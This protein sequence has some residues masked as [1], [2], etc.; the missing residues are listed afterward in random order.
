M[1][2]A[3]VAADLFGLVPGLR[4]AG[5]NLQESLKDSGPGSG[6]GR[7]HERIRSI[8]VV[9]EVALACVL[10]VGAGLLLRS[11]MQVLDVD[12]GFQPER[13]AAVKVDYDDNVPN[14]KDGAQCAQARRHLPA[15]LSRVG[16][17]PGVE[18]AGIVGLPAPWPES[19]MGTALP[20]GKTPDNFKS[21]IA[22]GLCC[23]SWISPRHG[24]R[25]A[26]PRHYLGRRP[27]SENVVRDDQ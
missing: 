1:L 20:K 25:H 21:A 5:G 8:L 16:A 9:T 26:R 6:Q 2:I 4:M 22:A 7:K 14:D 18:A 3:V 19:R 15:V 24:H 12:L 23:D 10:L 17:I 13:A 27:K 11:F